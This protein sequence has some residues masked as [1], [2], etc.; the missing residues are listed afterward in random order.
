MA[1][2]LS[3]PRETEEITWTLERAWSSP[4]CRITKKII[5]PWHMAWRRRKD[6]FYDGSVYASVDAWLTEDQY[7]ITKLKGEL[8]NV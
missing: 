3:W 8:N 2:Q 1:P 7:L 5:W 6:F 4:K